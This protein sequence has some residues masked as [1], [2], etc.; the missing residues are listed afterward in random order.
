MPSFR[1]F[2][3]RV[4]PTLTIALFLAPTGISGCPM[5]ALDVGRK[6]EA[7]MSD[8][9][10]VNETRDPRV[11]SEA[12]PYYIALSSVHRYLSPCHRTTQWQWCCVTLTM[13]RL[14]AQTD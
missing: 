2:R 1:P 11:V 3:S 6:W 13:M 7:T 5:I 4:N 9:V 12:C 10:D 8:D 14:M